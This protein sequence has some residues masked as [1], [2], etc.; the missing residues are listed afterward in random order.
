MSFQKLI[1]FFKWCTIINIALF[2]L[3]ALTV[4]IAPNFVYE[5]QGLLFHLPREGFDITIYALLGFYKV[6]I[7]VFNLAPYLALL[8]I[9]KYGEQQATI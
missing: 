3:S 1:A 8:I 6:I 2:M 9:Q 4:I 7:L 5:T